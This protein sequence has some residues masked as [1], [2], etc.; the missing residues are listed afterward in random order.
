MMILLHIILFVMVEK[1][2]CTGKIAFGQIM[3]SDTEREKNRDR[4]EDYDVRKS[5]ESFIGDIANFY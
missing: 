5:I 4:D 2:A 3:S 1:L